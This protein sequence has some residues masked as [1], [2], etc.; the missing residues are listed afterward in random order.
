MLEKTVEEKIKSYLNSKN[1]YWIKNHGSS[2]TPK[3]I[4]DLTCCWEGKF[5]AIE[6][7]M[8]GKLNGQSEHQKI[9]MNNILKAGG[10]YILAD[11]VETVIKRLEE[12]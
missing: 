7:K 11:N 5:L 6:V 12:S 1:V 10:I 2:F 3:G 4:P 8:T 9:H